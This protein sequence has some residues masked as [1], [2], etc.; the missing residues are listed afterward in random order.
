MKFNYKFS[1]IA[2]LLCA[3][4]CRSFAQYGY[5]GFSQMDQARMAYLDFLK[6][7]KYKEEGRN[8]IKWW[9]SEGSIG[10]V[11]STNAN[12]EQRSQFDGTLYGTPSLDTTMKG[13]AKALLG[14]HAN[15]NSNHML[16]RLGASSIL[17]FSWGLQID[18]LRWKLEEF[19]G[20]ETNSVVS[21]NLTYWQTGLPLT[22]DYKWGCDVD[23]E[24]EMKTCFAVGAG[25]M[26]LVGLSFDS[27]GDGGGGG[28]IAPYAYASFG[29]YAWGCWKLRVSYMPG[30]FSILDSRTD[31]G[32]TV[33]TMKIQGD[34]II[35]LGIANMSHSRDWKDGGGWRGSHT[36]GR[37]GG[38]T[39]YHKHTGGMRRMF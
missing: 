4:A 32:S 22:I 38:R 28:R 12:F 35:T 10:I 16:A 6:Y 21:S 13:T 24:P 15:S 29:V 8:L 23:F 18:I 3:F 19:N 2:A 31:Y 33:N 34:H 11:M 7:K 39:R 14:L 26:P 9:R 17:S 25:V 36:G 37:S 20:N 30:K 27:H 5:G 1:L